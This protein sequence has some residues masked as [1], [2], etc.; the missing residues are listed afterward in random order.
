MSLQDTK[1]PRKRQPST[2]VAR[3]DSPIDAFT[4]SVL[5][6]IDPEVRDTLSPAQI[7]AVRDA[8][9]AHQLLKGHP[10]DVRGILPL[11]FARYYFVFLMGRDRRAPTRE[12]EADRR[13]KTALLGGGL[14]F[15]CAISP[16]ILLALLFL[17]LLKS[18]LGIDLLPDA[19]LW[20]LLPLR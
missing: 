2:P 20:D 13:R 16:L 11:F 5:R 1:T 4:D 3:D 12:I 8:V 19:H 14:F 10:V 9:S 6:R 18:S 15:V 7:E 17:Y